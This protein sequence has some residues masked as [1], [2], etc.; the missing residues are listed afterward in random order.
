MIGTNVTWPK[1]GDTSIDSLLNF[2]KPVTGAYFYVPNMLELK[3]MSQEEVSY[4][5]AIIGG[6]V[7]GLFTGYRLIHHNPSLKIAVID[8]SSHVGGRLVSIPAPETGDRIIT[9]FG[10]MR[11][12]STFPYTNKIV[13][14]MGLEKI[15][16][17]V[18][19]DINPF[20]VRGR[21]GM[22]RTLKTPKGAKDIF[23]MSKISNT[24]IKNGLFIPLLT[25]LGWHNG[26]PTNQLERKNLRNYLTSVRLD[27]NGRLNRS[28]DAGEL[29]SEM[30]IHQL[31]LKIYSLEALE[32]QTTVSGYFS[33]WG[34]WN[35]VDAIVD[36]LSDFG[37]DVKYFRL[38]DGYQSLVLEMKEKF[39]EMGGEVFLAR[40]LAS[41]SRSGSN[42]FYLD[43]DE[44]SP[45]VARDLVLAMP[46]K[47]LSSIK[48]DL[49]AAPQVQRMIQSVSPQP[50]FKLFMCYE[51][52]WWKRE[53]KSLEG[54]SITDL[55]IRQCYYW[56]VDEET[57][58][59]VVMFYDD[60]SN[61]EFWSAILNR[62][63][64]P[65]VQNTWADN[66]V[67]DNVKHEAHRQ[68]ATLLNVN[69]D[70]VPKP[71]AA[72]CA[73]WSSETKFGGGVNFW[74][75]KVDSQKIIKEIIQPDPETRLFICGSAYSNYQGWVEGALE[76]ADC[77]LTE[78]FNLE[79]F[80][81]PLERLNIQAIN[82]GKS[83]I[84]LHFDSMAAR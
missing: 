20:Y 13:K 57:K 62:D 54:R 15:K 22:L 16:F 8:S 27:E 44:G 3:A 7:S 40:K 63:R 34:D 80:V 66:K 78:K 83:S 43:F 6:G 71:Y 55:P 68:F 69:P 37:R 25:H 84:K 58:H 48:S 50:Y 31:W 51:E 2:S 14:E 32:Y 81:S 30:S 52:A 28:T 12:P 59:A 67:A 26:P 82:A 33:A 77:M 39:C 61:P 1:K 46:R 9:E 17:P 56:E 64:D 60:G 36:N 76:S 41:F 19:S 21:N 49:L 18:D 74:L 53:G 35:A 47:C 79:G 70:K 72:S 10:G 75:P 65:D 24:D 73:Y 42:A 11:F 4:D 23:N 5:V 38:K 45:L 29:L